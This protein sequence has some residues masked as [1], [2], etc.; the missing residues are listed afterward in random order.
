MAFEI[1]DDDAIWTA[2][3][4][5]TEAFLSWGLRKTAVLPDGTRQYPSVMSTAIIAAPAIMMAYTGLNT[6]SNPDQQMS[7][8]LAAFLF[9]LGTSSV[10]G[11]TIPR[12]INWASRPTAPIARG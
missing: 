9:G 10:I 8:K 11:Y 5:A 3:G 1:T 4:G 12:L 6:D 2:I 7:R